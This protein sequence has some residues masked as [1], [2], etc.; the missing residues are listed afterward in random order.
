MLQ[1][2]KGLIAANKTR[3]AIAKMAQI[4]GDKDADL[5]NSLIMASA[6]IANN[7]SLFSMRLTDIEDYNKTVALTTRLVLATLD[8]LK[9][10][11]YFDN[12]AAVE[13]TTAPV[14]KVDN[15]TKIQFLAANPSNLAKLQLEREYIEIRKIFKHHQDKF[16]LTEEFDVTLE[17][18][19]EAIFV[20]KPKIV[21]FSG[22]SDTGDNPSLIFNRKNG[23]YQ[24]VSFEYLAATFKLFRDDVECVFIN[25]AF[26]DTFAK[27][28]SRFIPNVIGIKEIIDDKEAITFA[29]GFYTALSF[30]KNYKNA[31]HKAK[32][33][34]I[35]ERM[36]VLPPQPLHIPTSYGVAKVKKTTPQ[37]TSETTRETTAEEDLEKK[38][39]IPYVMFSNGE[40]VHENDTTPDDFLQN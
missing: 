35:S 3:E 2:L 38:K 8:E 11:G 40:A 39:Y 14:V 31:F 30:E 29:S 15:R 10:G 9:E 16:A 37:T 22:F 5:L 34:L 12:L 1:E 7:E 17:S 27:V 18:F 33:L 20:Q 6:Q 32:D 28:V 25:A 23:T 36:R 4:I 26:S 13:A 21:H 19:F 24:C